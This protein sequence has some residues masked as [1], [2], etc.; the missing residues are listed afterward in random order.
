MQSDRIQMEYAKKFGEN[1]C[2]LPTFSPTQT[3]R[4]KKFNKKHRIKPFIV[5]KSVLM[6]I[7]IFVCN[8][9]CSRSPSVDR[10]DIIKT[11]SYQIKHQNVIIQSFWYVQSN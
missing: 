1:D 6:F 9:N 5:R 11:K 8:K 7:L 2:Y 3:Q 4:F 10:G